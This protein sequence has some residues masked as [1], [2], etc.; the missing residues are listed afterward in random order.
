MILTQYYSSIVALSESGL[1][2]AVAAR[3]RE[4]I[5]F[6]VQLIQGR[7]EGVNIANLGLF[8]VIKIV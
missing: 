8:F 6:K 1:K 2:L 4:K 3:I 7:F 5:A